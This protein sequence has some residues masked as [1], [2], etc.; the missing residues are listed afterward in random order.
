MPALWEAEASGS[1]KVRSSRPA[2]PTWQNPVSTK[3][4]T[5]KNISWVWWSVPVIPA[6]QEAEAGESFNPRGRGC[7]EPRSHHCT[8][9]WAT[10]WDSVAKKKKFFF[11]VQDVTTEQKGLLN[12]GGFC[13]PMSIK[14]TETKYGLNRKNLGKRK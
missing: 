12:D 13:Y 2:C 11:Q 4:K 1:P 7:S 10:E 5:Y 9:A 3:K 6:T 14:G 8:P